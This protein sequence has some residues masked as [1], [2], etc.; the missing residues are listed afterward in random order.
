MTFQAKLLFFFADSAVA[1]TILAKQN[2]KEY[3]KNKNYTIRK[4]ILVSP[5]GISVPRPT[6]NPLV[7]LSLWHDHGRTGSLEHIV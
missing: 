7:G 3:D 2:N 5:F 4:N 6:P 1:S